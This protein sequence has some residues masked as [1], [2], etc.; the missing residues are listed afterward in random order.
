MLKPL[1][2]RKNSEGLIFLGDLSLEKLVQKYETP[3]Y[4]ICEKTLRQKIQEYKKSFEKEGL[5]HLVIYASKALNTKTILRII[6]QEALGLDVVSGGELYTALQVGFPTNKII[7]HGNN[8]SRDEIKMAIDHEILALIL[9]N[10]HELNLIEE[11]LESNPKAKINLML[12]IKPGIE[13]H[14][15]EYIKT[16]SIDSKFGFN[17]EDLDPLFKRLLKIQVKFSG[18]KVLGLHAHIGSQ[19][20]ETEPHADTVSLMLNLYK[21]L[22]DDFGFEFEYLNIGGGLGIQYLE[23]DDPPE[24]SKWI[25]V[26][27]DSLKSNCSKLGLKIPK[28]MVEPG[29]SLVGQAGLTVYRV[30]SLKEIQGLRN[31]LSVDGGMADNPRPITYQSEYLAEIDAKR[32]QDA[33]KTYRIVGKFCESGDVLIPEIDLPEAKPGDL[34]VIYATGAYNYSMS[35]N[36]NRVPRPAMVL[37]EGD[38]SDIIV[39][40]ETYEDLVSRDLLPERFR[41]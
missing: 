5:E 35:S 26:I 4:L 16:G 19:I 13:C 41:K 32:S 39:S 12:R 21:R 6:D 37:V 17:L 11:H 22:R 34:L 28:L 10:E 31:Y 9:D 7:F 27:S 29:R 2:Y 14:T 18:L 30:G 36:Y 40:R 1:S 15:H 20:F 33:K 24:I 23:T 38:K 8:K 25:K 3:L